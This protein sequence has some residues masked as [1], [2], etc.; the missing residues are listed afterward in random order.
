LEWAHC[1]SSAYLPAAAI[2]RA[3]W[4]ACHDERSGR[5]GKSGEG[6]EFFGSVIEVQNLR[7][8]KEVGLGQEIIE[9]P[10]I[11]GDGLEFEDEGFA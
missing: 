6:V 8:I 2:R 5:N 9:A 3:A 11:L 1:F 10:F 7:D 4:V